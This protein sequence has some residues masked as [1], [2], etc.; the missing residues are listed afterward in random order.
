[1]ATEY[2]RVNMRYDFSLT[3]HTIYL[4]ITRA[5]QGK[6]P[7]LNFGFVFSQIALKLVKRMREVNQSACSTGDSSFIAHTRSFS[8]RVYLAL[9][10]SGVAET[11]IWCLIRSNHI[12]IRT[13]FPVDQYI[14]TP[15]L[16]KLLSVTMPMVS[17]VTWRFLPTL[18]DEHAD[19]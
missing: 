4:V 1:M 7:R 16:T 8:Q 11:Q 19:L 2:Q 14:S 9:N 17:S 3:S 12:Q 5:F 13:P 18:F 15:S 6:H 10:E